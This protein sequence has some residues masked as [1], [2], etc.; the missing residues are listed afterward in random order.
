MSRRFLELCQDVVRDLGIAGGTINSVSG[1]LNQEQLRVI[2]WVARADLYIQ[3]LWVDWLFL[4]NADSAVLAQAGSD[5]LTPTLPAWAASIQTVETGSLWLGAAGA[6]AR[7]IRYIEWEAFR[8]TFERKLKATSP[9]P[10]AWSQRPDGSLVLSHLSA[11]AQSFALDYHCVGK[12]LIGDN[13]VSRV[14]NAFDQVIVEKAKMY[15]A[16]RENAPEIMSGAIAEYTDTMDKMQAVCLPNNTASRRLKNN[17]DTT[18]SAYV[19]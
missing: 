16:E 3:N 19:E 18:P 1:T 12:R 13:D 10:V 7:P 11:S 15:Y 9:V 6:S 4:W 14:P 8:Q 17:P 2:N 5:L